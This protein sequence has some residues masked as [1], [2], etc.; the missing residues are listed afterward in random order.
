[1][2]NTIK[3]APQSKTVY[4]PGLNGLRAISAMAVVISHTT[5]ILRE[6]GLNP[7]ILG[8]DAHGN[9]K[10]LL[11]A[12]NGVTIFFTL[13]GFL[14]TYLLLMEK[15]LHPIKVKDFYV[16]RI[17]RIW[18]LYYLYLIAAIIAILHF[19]LPFESKSIPFY[20]LL[21]ANVPFI[22]G[23]ALP[24]LTHYWSLGVEEQFYLFFPQMARLPN[25]KLLQVSVAL[26]TGL[27]LLK[28]I[29][30]I[31][32]KKYKLSILPYIAIEDSR[33][34]VMLVGV[35][36][37]IM[38]YYRNSTFMTLATHKLTQGL[39]WFCILL[40]ALN[41]FHI[42]F[43][44]SELVSVIALFLIVGQVTK[45]GLI[46]LENKLCDFVGKISYSVYVIH[47]LVIYLLGKAIGKLPDTLGSY[48]LVYALVII[49][50]L[51]LAYLSYQYYEKPFLRLKTKFT[52]VKS[53]NTKII[54][55]KIVI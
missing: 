7:N 27:L 51:I 33:F 21:A 8:T 1:M 54:V 11:L 47:P 36:G 40:I 24:F 45:K 49:A 5:P 13:S 34:H 55:R 28:F 52:T 17:L 4:L 25:R 3:T 31:L 6:Y 23:T 38:Y 44:D 46:N 53:S 9:P 20:V 48:L 32:E 42:G 50:T 19:K 39:S 37:A 22:S 14:I 16:R 12:G 41:Y 29:F 10:G 2:N 30:W 15:K 26:I 43:I 18:P 35:A